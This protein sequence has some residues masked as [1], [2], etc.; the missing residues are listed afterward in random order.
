MSSFYITTTLPYVNAE[1]HIGFGWEITEADTLARYRRL[2]GDEVIF[3][4]GTDEHGLKIYRK[5]LENGQTPQQYCDEWAAKFAHLQELLNLS[6]THFIRTTDPHHLLAAQEFWRRCAANG[7]IYKK[8]YQV[9]Y[10]VGCELEKTESEL[11]DGRCPLHPKMDIE[12]IDEENYFFRFSKYQ[13][14]LLQLYHERPNFVQPAEKLREIVSFVEHGLQ[15]FSIS[16]L[17]S[18]MPWGIAVPDDEEQVM[19]VWFDALANYISTLGWPED[20]ANFTQ[21]WPG[22]QMAGKDNLRQQSAMWQAMLLSAQLP[23][24]QQIFINGF[25]SVGGQKMSK[26]LG[27]VISPVEMVNKYGVDGA[28]YILLSLGTFAGDVDVT[29]ER[30]DTKYTADLANGLGNLA[31]RLSKLAEKSAVVGAPAAPVWWPEYLA[32]MDQVQLT[33][34]LNLV[35]EKVTQ[36]D[37][38]LSS[39]KPWLLTGAEQTTAM[40]ALVKQYQAIL[41]HLQPFLPAT[42]EKLL[43]HFGQT[44]ITAL[45]PLFPRLATTK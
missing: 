29:W 31:S 38:L 40:T 6:Y 11:V 16:R 45:S 8:S 34:A 44:K 36:L 17:K 5:A 7:D 4:T 33:T 23:P 43:A 13:E 24:S 12:L 15:D 18:K 39:T 10:C 20:N 2:R 32:A 14:P 42:A 26:S 21:F 28:R 35:I 22:V 41:W 30:F 37:Q 1:P 25:I 3:N 19:Y 9:K 27:N